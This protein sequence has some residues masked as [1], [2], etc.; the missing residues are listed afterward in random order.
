MAELLAVR[1]RFGLRWSAAEWRGL[2]AAA[3]DADPDDVTAAIDALLGAFG[4]RKERR[5]DELWL[6]FPDQASLVHFRMV[7]G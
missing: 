1:H 4:G 7:Y 6:V 3:R 2:V 5:L